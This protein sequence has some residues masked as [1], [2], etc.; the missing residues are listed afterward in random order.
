M[1]IFASINSISQLKSG[2]I[3]FRVLYRNRTNR[4]YIK[5]K[6]HFIELALVVVGVGK[7]EICRAGQQPE[8]SDEKLVL[9]SWV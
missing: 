2:D 3:L 1:I 5:K 4:T 6:V 8:N 9:Q 7:F